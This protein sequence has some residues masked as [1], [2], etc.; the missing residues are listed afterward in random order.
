MLF[1][2]QLSKKWSNEIL[3]T[4]AT[5]CSSI[6]CS[7]CPPCFQSY[8]SYGYSD[9]STVI[10]KGRSFM[11]CSVDSFDSDNSLE[12]WHLWIQFCFSDV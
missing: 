5:F 11:V 10:E 7:Y 8:S 6:W 9:L 12:F 3:A 2:A 1:Y 4:L